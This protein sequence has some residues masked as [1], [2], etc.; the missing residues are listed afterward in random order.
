MKEKVIQNQAI[1]NFPECIHNL[2]RRKFIK[3][4]LG[5]AAVT[6]VLPY[7]GCSKNKDS[8]EPLAEAAGKL[9]K[10]DPGDERFWKI[11]KE[12]FPVRKNL[13]IMNTANLSPSPYPVQELVFEL[14][15]DEDADASF[16]NREKFN[17]LREL[18][19]KG[20]AEYLGA[21]PDEIVITRNTSEGN[22]M[23]ISGLILERGDEV[24]IWN[25]NHPTANIAWDV[26]AER[27]GFSVKRVKTPPIPESNEDF[28]KPF[29]DALTKRTR[30]LAFSHVSNISGVALPAKELCQMARDNGILT[31]VDGAQ[32]FGAHVINLNDMGCDFYTGSAHKWFCGPKEVGIL[33]VRTDRIA[34]MYPSIVGA[35]W[36]NSLKNGAR[37]FEALGQ[38]DD[39]RVASMGKTVEFH[40]TI[41]KNRIEARMRTLANVMKSELK[42]KIR[43]IKFHTPIKPEFSGGI[44]VFTAPGIDLSEALNTLYH[45][46]NIGCTVMSGDFAG[47][48]LSPHIY[49]SMLEVDKVAIAVASLV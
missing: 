40:N 28:V 29:R 22:N 34:G 21:S 6:A 31:L 46:H 2:P 14:T 45:K 10:D 36:E 48:R 1:Q 16:T 47:I 33:Y 15:R 43:N 27:Y 25:Q 39:A 49:N 35:G 44:V 19:R 5:G 38:R 7:I 30:V 41:G 18:A 11:V 8:F 23:V 17:D 4:L 32:T 9:S 12:Q 26:R 20:L 13:I 37:K 3:R 42:R 24:V